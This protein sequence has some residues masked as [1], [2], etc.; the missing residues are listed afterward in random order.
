MSVARNARDSFQTKIERRQRISGLLH[1]WQQKTAQASVNMYRNSI[2]NTQLKLL[3]MFWIFYTKK[4]FQQIKTK[5][6]PKKF[7][8]FQNIY[9]FFIRILEIFFQFRS[10]KS[11]QIEI[12]PGIPKFSKL[13]IKE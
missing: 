6:F 13:L 5:S 1:E 3:M 11:R 12:F 10:N 2:A 7:E 9:K 8:N 4:K